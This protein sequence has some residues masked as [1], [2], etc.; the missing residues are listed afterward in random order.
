M[1]LI[2]L[3]VLQWLQGLPSSRQSFNV[4]FGECPYCNKV[5]KYGENG[6][7]QHGYFIIGFCL[8]L[9]LLWNS[10]C[11]FYLPFTQQ[12]KERESL[13]SIALSASV[14][15]CCS[16]KSLK[17]LLQ[18]VYTLVL[19]ITKHRAAVFHDFFFNLSVTKNSF[20]KN[21]QIHSI[22]QPPKQFSTYINSIRCR[23]R[24]LKRTC[25]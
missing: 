18:L 16:R 17:M 13:D 8:H 5:R 11:S 23:L 6:M 25:F 1:I 12:D 3:L 14:F 7:K 15:N 10:S 19:K 22:E 9:S 21:P 2:Y 4:I 24:R 20:L